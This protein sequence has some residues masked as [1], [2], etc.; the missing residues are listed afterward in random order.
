LNLETISELQADIAE[1]ERLTLQMGWATHKQQT[2][3]LKAFN[4]TMPQF[5]I[6]RALQRLQTGCT[7]SELGTAAMQV[8]ATVTGIIDR[9]EEQMLLSRQPNPTDRRSY[10][11]ILT[12]KGQALLQEIDEQ[13]RQ[14]ISEIFQDLPANQR[15]LL[16]QILGKY[17]A[18][19]VT[20]DIEKE[21]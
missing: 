21:P 16:L 5:M 2:Q 7:M 3:K 15:Q 13:R 19:L 11:I 14:H 4:L 12:E 20:E 10:L 6:L 8:P 18:V 17:L 9:L 1:M